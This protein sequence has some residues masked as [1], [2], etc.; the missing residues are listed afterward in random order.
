MTTLIETMLNMCSSIVWTYMSE[1]LRIQH[2]TLQHIQIDSRHS[3]IKSWSRNLIHHQNWKLPMLTK[4]N[5]H[6][7]LINFGKK[8]SKYSNMY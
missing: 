2:W 1:P 4:P 8:Y 5:N 6:F 3:S 7:E